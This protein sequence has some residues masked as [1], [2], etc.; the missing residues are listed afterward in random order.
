MREF[1]AYLA[2]FSEHAPYLNQQIAVIAV[3]RADGVEVVFTLV[4]SFLRVV[5]IIII[6]VRVVRDGWLYKKANQ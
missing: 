3:L 4:E 6:V 1:R 5:I 2:G